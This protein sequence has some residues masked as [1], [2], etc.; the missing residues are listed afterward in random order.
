MSV[1]QAIA[2]FPEE[3]F[4]LLKDNHGRFIVFRDNDSILPIDDEPEWD[5]RVAQTAETRRRTV[6]ALF[7]PR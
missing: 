5:Y 3:G 6:P 1:I 7:R 4:S 2:D